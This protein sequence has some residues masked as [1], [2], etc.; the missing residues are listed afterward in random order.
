[1]L[2]GEREAAGC[3]AQAMDRA[4]GDGIAILIG[5]SG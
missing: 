5:R 1:L 2:R 4:R 3:I